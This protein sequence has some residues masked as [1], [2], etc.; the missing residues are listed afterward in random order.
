MLGQLMQDSPPYRDKGSA[1]VVYIIIFAVAALAVAGFFYERNQM[2][3]ALNDKTEQIA[4]LEKT[5]EE[6]DGRIASLEKDKESLN[7]QIETLNTITRDLTTKRA[8]AVKEKNELQRKLEA[9]LSKL[10]PVLTDQE[11]SKETEAEKINSGKRIMTIWDVYCMKNEHP[12]CKKPEGEK[13]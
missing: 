10:P 3:K 5:V 6:Q 1:I 12:S 7:K 11:V 8:E 4:K 13:K 2:V 9:Y